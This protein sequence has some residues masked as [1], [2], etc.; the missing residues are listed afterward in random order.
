MTNVS[1]LL[2]E[3]LAK[4]SDMGNMQVTSIDEARTAV[5]AQILNKKSQEITEPINIVD[6]TEAPKNAGSVAS[7]LEEVMQKRTNACKNDPAV[8]TRRQQV[9]QQAQFD[10][11]ESLLR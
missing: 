11:M 10:I 1:D 2:R 3:S 5:M 8:D 6:A 9:I 7:L 4:R